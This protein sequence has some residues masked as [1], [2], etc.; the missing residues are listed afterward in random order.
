M[1]LITAVSESKFRPTNERTDAFVKTFL[2]PQIINFELPD[3]ARHWLNA[4]DAVTRVTPHHCN[5]IWETT[6]V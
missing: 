5:A 1:Q 2:T 3:I 6:K 4:P